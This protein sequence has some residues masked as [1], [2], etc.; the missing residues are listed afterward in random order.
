MFGVYRLYIVLVSDSF[1][2]PRLLGLRLS[3]VENFQDFGVGEASVRAGFDGKNVAVVGRAVLRKVVR[4]FCHFRGKR[5]VLLIWRGEREERRREG[6]EGERV[7]ERERGERERGW[8][9][10]RGG[11][12]ERGREGGGKREGEGGRE[13]GGKREGERVEEREREREGGKR[14]GKER[15]RVENGGKDTEKERERGRG[16]E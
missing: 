16:E 10:E 6:R 5:I 3:L 1:R 12:G 2:R 14:E 7:E 15:E 13:G 11:G 9:K 8:R 4:F